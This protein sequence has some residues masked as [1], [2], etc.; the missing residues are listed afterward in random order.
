LFKATKIGERE[1]KLGAIPTRK[2][3][4]SINS[5]APTFLTI[6]KALC[7]IMAKHV[8]F[9]FPRNFISTY[10]NITTIVMLP[11]QLY[12]VFLCVFRSCVCVLWGL[13][14]LI[15]INWLNAIIVNFCLNMF[16]LVISFQQIIKTNDDETFTN[17]CQTKILFLWSSFGNG[18]IF[19][20]WKENCFEIFVGFSLHRHN[21][22]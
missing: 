13:E 9:Y 8:N 14:I 22:N 7:S 1:K 10:H 21:Q 19:C 5:T 6:C 18:E 2:E 20:L 3:Q 12:F 17:V 16:F 15:S 4:R 11:L